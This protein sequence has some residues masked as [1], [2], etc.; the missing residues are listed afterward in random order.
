VLKPMATAPPASTTAPVP[1]MA[2]EVTDE[3]P[4][5]ATAWEQPCRLER[6]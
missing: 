2:R 5:D 6:C 4:F 1:R 3:C